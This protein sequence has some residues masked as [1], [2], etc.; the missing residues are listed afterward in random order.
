MKKWICLVVCIAS[1][2]IFSCCSLSPNFASTDA[3]KVYS[4]RVSWEQIKVYRSS[5]PD[6]PY[7]EIGSVYVCC[8]PDADELVDA[9]KKKAA[10]CGGDAI[11]AVEPYPDGMSATVIRFK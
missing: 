9:L 6:V 2:L 3:S 5:V 11:I 4:Q 7:L 10:K 8:H 1:C